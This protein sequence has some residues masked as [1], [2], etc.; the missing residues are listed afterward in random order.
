M[1]TLI[2]TLKDTK[3]GTIIIPR[4]TTKAITTIDG[5][6]LDNKMEYINQQLANHEVEVDNIKNI[7]QQLVDH[8]VEID[9]IKKIKTATILTNWAGSTA[10]YTQ[11]ITVDGVTKNDNPIISPIY[12]TTNATAILE[13]AAWNL[14]GKITT[15]NDSITVACFEAKPTQTLNIQIKGV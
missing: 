10:P 7:N 3:T 6:L 2:K 1:E 13:K 9:N 14:I 8:K 15:N 12:S 4:T 11:T 5:T